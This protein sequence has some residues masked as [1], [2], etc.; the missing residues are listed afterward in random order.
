MKPMQQ[1]FTTRSLT[2]SHTHKHRVQVQLHQIFHL[3]TSSEE[4]ASS[5]LY[6]GCHV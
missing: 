3:L 4:E 5:D 1:K 2:H 6:E